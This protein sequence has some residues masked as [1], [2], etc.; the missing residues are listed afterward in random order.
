MDYG[1][2]LKAESLR[3]ELINQRKI[4]IE[5]EFENCLE[6]ISN[7]LTETQMIAVRNL[8]RYGFVDKIHDINF[9][10]DKLL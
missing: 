4:E 8:L 2:K 5:N 7:E 6:M 1:L 3:E 10:Y 9:E